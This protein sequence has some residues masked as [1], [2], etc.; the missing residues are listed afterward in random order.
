MEILGI[1]LET[2]HLQFEDKFYRHADGKAKNS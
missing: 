2:T 1:S